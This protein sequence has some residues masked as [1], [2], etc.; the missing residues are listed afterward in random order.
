MPADLTRPPTATLPAECCKDSR[1]LRGVWSTGTSGTHPREGLSE[2]EPAAGLGLRAG[3]DVDLRAVARA[4][5][6]LIGPE[7]R[8]EVSCTGRTLLRGS[9]AP[10]C[11]IHARLP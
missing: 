4:R 10:T 1:S 9:T 6:S 11:G 5:V 3:V 2:V 8:S 7:Q